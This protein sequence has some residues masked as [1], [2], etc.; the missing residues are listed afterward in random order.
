MKLVELGSAPTTRFTLNGGKRMEGLIPEAYVPF[1]ER[2]FAA[3]AHPAAVTL[4]SDVAEAA[5]RPVAQPGVRP[6]WMPDWVEPFAWTIHAAKKP[7]V[8]GTLDRVDW[9][10]EQGRGALSACGFEARELAGVRLGG[11]GHAVCAETIAVPLGPSALIHCGGR[12]SP[13]FVPAHAV[14]I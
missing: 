13:P 7:I 14:T 2:V 8:S 4:E 1:A 12:R 6:D 3:F 5:W 11:R 10:A 9:S